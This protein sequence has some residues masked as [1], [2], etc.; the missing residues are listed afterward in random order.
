M[1]LQRIPTP[2][3]CVAV[4]FRSVEDAVR[5]IKESTYEIQTE[6][7]LAYS[8][9]KREQNITAVL[10]KYAWLYNLDTVQRIE[11]AY[12]EETDSENKERVRRVYY[13]LLGGHI[14]QQIA[15]LEDALVS[16]EAGATVE[17][18][19][20][21]IPYY[22]V[23]VLIAGEHDFGRRNRLREASLGVVEESNPKRLEIL[24][25]VLATLADGFG[26]DSYTAYNAE[27]KRIDYALLRSRM[28]SLLSETEE[29]YQALMGRWVEETT[30]RRLEEIASHHVS[31][32]SRVPQ[33]DEYFRKDR[34]LGAYEQTLA[35]MGLDPASQDN[36]HIDT[37]ERATKN[38]RARCYA[39]DPPGEVHLLIKPV[40]GLEDYMAFFHEAGHAQHFGNED[41]TLDY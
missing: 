7:R 17:V 23:P 37:E 33:Y 15:P 30:G 32:I 41:P 13:H 25:T 2:E 20:E 1:R 18:D 6:S 34:L 11:E 9:I 12:R 16:F 40:G 36:I 22:N 29:T 31:Y 14:E 19:G 28:E 38:P 26:H 35:M 8:G 5:G 3:G 27:K 4:E 10:K 24:R 39:P 21:N